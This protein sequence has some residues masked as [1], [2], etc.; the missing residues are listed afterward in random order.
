MKTIAPTYPKF[1]A[2]D[3]PKALQVGRGRGEAV[4]DEAGR[5]GT[6]RD[7]ADEVGEAGRGRG[8]GRGRSIGFGGNDF[9]YEYES[10]PHVSPSK[11][12]TP[13]E[14]TKGFGSCFSSYLEKET[15]ERGLASLPGFD[16]L[17]G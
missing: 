4:G 1:F 2:D 13:G 7:E 6:R 11:G 5:G 17:R 12:A 15:R 16:P 14:R 3:L 8:R 10:V 9:E